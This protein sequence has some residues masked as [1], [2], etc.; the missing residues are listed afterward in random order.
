MGKQPATFACRCQRDWGGPPWTTQTISLLILGAVIVL[1]IWNRL[2]VGAVAI[3][4]SLSLYATGVLTV[5]EALSGFGDLVVVFIASLFVV[6][7]G[8]D[9]AGVTTWAGRWLL[10]VIGDRAR[11]ALVAVMAMAA[12]MSALITLNGA[13]AALIPMV[14][15]I[16]MRLGLA[17]RDAC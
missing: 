15:V 4:A 16:A 11:V 10:S 6:S 17:A 2:P 13:A 14:V 7:E 9:S 3:L 1:F 5:E 12:V 8:I